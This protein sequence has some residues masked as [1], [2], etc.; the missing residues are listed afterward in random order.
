MRQARSEAED[1]GSDFVTNEHVILG[2]L[3]EPDGLAAKSIVA[4]GLSLDQLRAITL[5]ALGPGHGAATG[6]VPFAPGAK[7]TLQLALREALHL[8]HNYIGTE[9]LL[10]ALLRNDADPG[11]RLLRERGVTRAHVEQQLPQ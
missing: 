8:G 6:R 3:S 5:D 7:K 9:H 4:A 2:L 1:R 11:A 10:L